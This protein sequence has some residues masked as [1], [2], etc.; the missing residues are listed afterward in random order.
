MWSALQEASHVIIATLFIQ[1][2][3]K[4]GVIDW[5]SILM[6]EENRINRSKTLRVRLRSTEA[7]PTY[8]LMAEASI[9]RGSQRGHLVTR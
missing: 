8:V 2:N 5:D 3:E 7:Q 9:E 1:I 4:G 6:R